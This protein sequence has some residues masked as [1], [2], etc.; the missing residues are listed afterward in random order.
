[1][2]YR[3]SKGMLCRTVTNVPEQPSVPKMP[4]SISAEKLV[5]QLLFKGNMDDVIRPQNGDIVQENGQLYFWYNNFW[6]E[7][8]PVFDDVEQSECIEEKKLY[9]QI[10]KCCGAQL[11][12]MTC[13]YCGT[14]Y[15]EKEIMI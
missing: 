2:I 11:H 4:Q 9:P 6:I 3:D 1:M 5:G 13:E 12:G 8:G 15:G 14:E 10:C 7:C